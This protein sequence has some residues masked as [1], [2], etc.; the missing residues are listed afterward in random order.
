M[1]VMGRDRGRT[2]WHLD[3]EPLP[4]AV[5]PVL[6]E[7]QQ[8]VVDHRHGALLV[9][10]GPGTGKTTTIVEA[11]VARLIDPVDPIA[12]E[13]VLAL[14]F[15]KRAA[16][17]L[18]DRLVGRLGGGVLPT[19]ATFHSFAFGLLQQTAT[20]Q[21]YREPPQLLSG[22]EEDVRIREL[23]MGAVEDGTID[24]P[25]DLA[26]AVSTIGLANEV[27]AVLAKAKVLGITPEHLERL[28]LESQRPAWA[29][30]GRLA[31]QEADVM[32]WQN[33]LDYVE[34][35]SA[36]VARAHS[37][38]VAPTLQQQY[39]LICVD[40]YQDTDPLQVELLRALVGPNTTVI[41]VG[42]PDQSIYGFRGAD[43]GGILRFPEEFG[44][45][46]APAPIVLLRHTRRFGP[47]IRDAATRIIE[48]VRL[49]HIDP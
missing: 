22:A 16:S 30:V 24:W 46:N 21:D 20:A 44:S 17:D 1:A 39:R 29:T 45:A 14:T 5:A 2:A 6:D 3:L 38:H 34:L 25:D 32:E 37:E 42:D 8:A 36:A 27:R 13:Q 15:G 35:L 28:G 9:L 18:R 26:G 43:L 49:A 48:K 47:E 10:A 41:A 4:P 33:V 23:L 40:E 31:A 12:P 11:I 19:V 7:Q